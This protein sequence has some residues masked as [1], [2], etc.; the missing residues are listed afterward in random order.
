MLLDCINLK[1]RNSLENNLNELDIEV[2]TYL[3]N[4]GCSTDVRGTYY[5]KD[6]IISIIE[7]LLRFSSLSGEEIQ[8]LMIEL[9]NPYSQFYLDLARNK[10][11]LGINTFNQYIR[12]ATSINDEE[13]TGLRAYQIAVDILQ[14]RGIYIEPNAFTRKLELN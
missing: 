7:K 12:Q 10:H 8:E 4:M 2:L 13:V 5:F 14:N 11:D 9:N 3:E 1:Y 6:M